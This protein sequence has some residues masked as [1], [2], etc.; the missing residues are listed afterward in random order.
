MALALVY[1]GEPTLARAV[2]LNHAHHLFGAGRQLL[3][4]MGNPTRGGLLGPRQ[5]PVSYAQRRAGCLLAGAALNQTEPRRR[6]AFVRLPAVRHGQRLTIFGPNHAQHSNFRHAAHA[7]ERAA[8]AVDQALFGHVLEQRLEL[9]LLLPFQAES[10]RNLTLS[11]GFFAAGDEIQDLLAA[12]Q[13]GLLLGA[14]HQVNKPGRRK[15]VP[16]PARP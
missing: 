8:V 7:V 15:C 10:A 14:F 6:H 9:D 3:H 12:R 1:R 16:P 5:D 4:R 11:S 2:D 13:T